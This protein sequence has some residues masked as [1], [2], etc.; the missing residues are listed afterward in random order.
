MAMAMPVQR[1]EV[2][3]TLPVPLQVAQKERAP[4]RLTSLPRVPHAAHGRYPVPLQYTHRALAWICDSGRAPHQHV[5][6][7]V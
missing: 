7:S 3:M 1:Q 5:R 6:G 2:H 4:S